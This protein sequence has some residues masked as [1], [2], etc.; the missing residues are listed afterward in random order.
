MV[1][2]AID[3]GRTVCNMCREVRACAVGEEPAVKLWATRDNVAS[4]VVSVSKAKAR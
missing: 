1:D 3:F 4:D 2:E